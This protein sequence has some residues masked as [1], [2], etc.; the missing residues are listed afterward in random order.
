[1]NEKKIINSIITITAVLLLL[2]A[3]W[4]N[5]RL[6]QSRDAIEQYRARELEHQT[7]LNEL[8][9]RT[10]SI[11]SANT[12]IRA[13]ADRQIG[14]IGELREV[15]AEIRTNCELLE[16]RINRITVGIDSINNNC[17]NNQLE[18]EYNEGKDTE[19]SVDDR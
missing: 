16:M 7:I 3:V 18:E 13:A 17:D 4:S 11:Q 12:A 15:L 2:W 14:S 9:E 19:Q 10:N 5:I 8:R 6:G 1:M